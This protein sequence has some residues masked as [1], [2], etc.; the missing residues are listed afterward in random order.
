MTHNITIDGPTG[1]LDALWTTTANAADNSLPPADRK[2][3]CALLCHPHPQY[4]GSMHDGVLAIAAGVLSA[5]GIAHL[6]FN[7]R[8]VGGSAGQFDNGKGEGDDICAAWNWL[9]EQSH[10]GDAQT[11]WDQ[12]LLIGYS[13]GAATAWSVR[14]RCPNLQQLVL[15]APPTQAMPFV[16]SAGAINTQVVVGDRDSYCDLAALPEGAATTVLS[17]A[18]HFFSGSTSELQDAISAALASTT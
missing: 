10:N 11:P 2:S 9:A 3:H 14:E 16:G 8:G 17:G 7:F 12:M 18:D 13:F 15:I 4:G 1:S 6:R 5:N